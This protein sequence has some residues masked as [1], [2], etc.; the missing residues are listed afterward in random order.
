MRDPFYYISDQ[1]LKI[2]LMGIGVGVGIGA[3]VGLIKWVWGLF[4]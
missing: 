3:V 2:I 4:I 1:Y